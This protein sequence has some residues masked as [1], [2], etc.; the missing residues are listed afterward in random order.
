MY[1]TSLPMLSDMPTAYERNPDALDFLKAVPTTWDETIGLDGRIGEWAAAGAAE[2]RRLVGGRDDRLGPADGRAC[3]SASWATA[4]GRRPSGRTG[5]TPTRWAR[6][7]GGASST[8][9]PGGRAAPR[10]GARAAAPS[11]ACAAGEADSRR[12]VEL[13]RVRGGL[14]LRID[15]T[16]ASV[17]RPG[18]GVT[19]VVWWALASPVLL[20]PPSRPRRV[21]L[22]GLAA[23]S[24][25][26]AVRA[27]DP[28][29]EIVGVDLDRE[30]LRLA[31]R[32]FGLDRLRVEVVVGDALEYLRRERRRFDLIVEDL[33]VGPSRSVRKPDWLLGR[34]LPPHPQGGSGPGGFVVSNTIHETPASSEP[35]ARSAGRIVSLDVRGHWNRVT[36]CGRSLPAAR[37]LRR[38]LGAHPSLALPA[39]A[40]G[41]SIPSRSGRLGEWSPGRLAFPRHGKLR[42]DVRGHR[43]GPPGEAPPVAR[44]GSGR[45]HRLEPGRVAPG[46]GPAR[47]R[48]RQLRDREAGQPRRGARASSAPSAGPASASSKATSPRRRPAGRR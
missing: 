21:L 24:V 43:G 1:E 3:R 47:R 46:A 22:L 34:G 29:A 44:H 37:A 38:A 35:C 33:F 12:A 6:T 41:A 10:S 31:R 17:Y 18:G 13:R 20:L 48:P 2:G 39:P 11:S 8:L 36:V 5:R 30:V 40:G 28:E 32:H 26:R 19:G 14:E 45:L 15:G 23:G 16:Q 4:P 25:A 9:S 7:T 42:H 27:L